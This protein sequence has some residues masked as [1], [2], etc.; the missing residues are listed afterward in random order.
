MRC[1]FY[2]VIYLFSVFT[3]LKSRFTWNIC[4]LYQNIPI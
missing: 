2:V 1:Y 3:R 4:S